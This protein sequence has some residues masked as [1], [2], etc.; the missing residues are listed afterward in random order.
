ME[1][2]NIKETM[3]QAVSNTVAKENTIE[4]KILLFWKNFSILN[5]AARIIPYISHP[6]TLLPNTLKNQ[7]TIVLRARI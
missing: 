3:F 7:F 2:Q 1:E 5:I 4:E 6:P